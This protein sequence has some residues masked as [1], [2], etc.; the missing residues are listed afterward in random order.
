MLASVVLRFSHEPLG[1]AEL[2]PRARRI[3]IAFFW[4]EV[5]AGTTSACAENTPSGRRRGASPRNYLR[6]RGEYGHFLAWQT[7]AWELPPRARRI[8]DKV[9]AAADGK[10]TT[11]A[12]AENTPRFRHCYVLSRN[13]L[14]VRGEYT[15]Y[16]RV[17][18]PELELPPRARRIPTPVSVRIFAL[19]TTSACAENTDSINTIPAIGGNYLRVRGEYTSGAV[20]RGE[21]EE[22]PPR[23]RRIRGDPVPVTLLGGTTSAC[24]ENT[25]L[26]R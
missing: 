16:R 2:P 5:T 18:H 8:R 13:Y 4:G 15:G 12:C 26:R 7:A 9:Y 25:R 23:A 17:V 10:G 22:L 21:V 20:K 6:V 3:P 1:D 24:A 19:G 11:S 14:R